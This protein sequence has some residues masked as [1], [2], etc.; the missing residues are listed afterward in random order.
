M[1]EE[2]S[3]QF[4]DVA[5]SKGSFEPVVFKV[6][7]MQPTYL[8]WVGYFG[9]MMSVDLFVLLD[10]VQFAKR[11]WQQRNQIKTPTGSQMLTVPVLSKGKRSQLIREVRIDMTREFHSSHLRALELNYSKSLNFSNIFPVLQQSIC[12]PSDS[13][14]ELNIR[15]IE[16]IRKILGISTPMLR[17]SN[18][19]A[20]GENAQLLANICLE[21]GAT[22]YVSPPGSRVYLDQSDAFAINRIP[23]EYFQFDCIPY[24]QQHGDFIPYMSIADLILNCGDASRKIIKNGI[25]KKHD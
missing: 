15:L 10:S 21:L 1:T 20:R 19:S 25:L 7:I 23:V 4:Q 8:P 11:S 14:V 2:V 12:N 9:L 16:D 17:S 3:T 24:T 18:L 5:V 22:T 13:L 6:A